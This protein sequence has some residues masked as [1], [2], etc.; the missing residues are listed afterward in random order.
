MWAVAAVRAE[1]MA[2]M[3]R[4]AAAAALV[5]VVMLAEGSAVVEPMARAATEAV[6]TR[7]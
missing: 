5:E 3:D 6:A 1:E 4:E 7:G 2:A